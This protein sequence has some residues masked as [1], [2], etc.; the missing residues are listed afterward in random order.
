VV[1]LRSAKARNPL[2]FAAATWEGGI[3]GD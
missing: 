2:S 1:F 3:K